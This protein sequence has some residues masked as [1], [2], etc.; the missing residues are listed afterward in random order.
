MEVFIIDYS[1][2]LYGREMA[3]DIVARL[4]GEQKYSSPDELKRQISRDIEQAKAILKDRGE[5]HG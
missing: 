4:R 1:G 3:I 5:S 2:D